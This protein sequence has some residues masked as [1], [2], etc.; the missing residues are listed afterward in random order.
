[1]KWRLGWFAILSG[2]PTPHHPPP[3][4]DQRS[5]C[6][7]KDKAFAGCHV[8]GYCEKTAAVGIAAAESLLG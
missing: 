4:I 6:G 5:Q 7:R 1:L 2:D 3:L 8:A